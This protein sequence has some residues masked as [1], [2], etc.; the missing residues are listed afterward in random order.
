MG[1]YYSEMACPTCGSIPCKCPRRADPDLSKWL[2]DN[3]LTVMTVVDHDAKYK[4]QQTNWGPIPGYPWSRRMSKQ[5]FNTCEEALAYRSEYL[6]LQIARAVEE[7]K[8]S[9]AELDILL[10]R[11]R[12]L[13]NE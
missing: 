6:A 13:L 1:H 11:Q 5:L 7:V 4:W 9:Q 3:D 2:V 8:D 12:G 10:D